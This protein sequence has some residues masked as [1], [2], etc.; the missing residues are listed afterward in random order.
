MGNRIQHKQI[1][2]LASLWAKPDVPHEYDAEFESTSNVLPANWVESF[3]PSGTIDPYTSFNTGVPKREI[4]TWRSSCYAIQA[5]NDG[6]YHTYFMSRPATIPTNCFLWARGSFSYRYN[7]GTNN[8]GVLGLFFS[9]TVT[10]QPDGANNVKMCLN[11]S[12]TSDPVQ[13]ETQKY[14]GG[15]GG[16][17]TETSDRGSTGIGQYYEYVG[18]QKIGTTYYFWAFSEHGQMY[19]IGTTTFAPTVDRIGFFVVNALDQSPGNTIATVDFVRFK[20]S[21][22]FLPGYGN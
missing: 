13:L 2:R 15:S 6:A 5:P 3:T 18:I 16:T 10:G 17:L 19:Y 20:E 12:D 22:V 14:T 1:S 4:G 11:E 7:Q 8:D 9:A 21:A